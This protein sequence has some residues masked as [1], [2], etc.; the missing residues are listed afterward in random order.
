M[1]KTIIDKIIDKSKCAYCKI[2]LPKKP[3]KKTKCKNCGKYIYVRT[4][5]DTRKKIL[6]TEEGAKE[7]DRLWEEKGKYEWVLDLLK[8]YRLTEKDLKRKVDFL[9]Q[10]YPSKDIDFK[11]AAWWPLSDL[12][13]QFIKEG[14]T[15][16]LSYLYWRMAWFLFNIEERNYFHLMTAYHEIKLREFKRNGIKKVKILTAKEDSC[17]HCQKNTNKILTIDEALDKKL[18]PCK[19]C[20]TF[21]NKKGIGWCRCCYIEIV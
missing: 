1:L 12:N 4:H 19:D 20:T 13:Y 7:I 3:L 11:E 10:K 2:E 21:I 5:P 17:E 8:Q 15:N 18:L 16:E 9:R 14:K 6:V